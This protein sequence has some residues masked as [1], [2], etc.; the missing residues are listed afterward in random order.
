MPKALIIA[1]PNGAGKTSFASEF[2]A[3][4]EG[5]SM[6][7]LNADL[8]ADELDPEN[9][10]RVAFAAGK[11]MLQQLSAQIAGGKNF[12]LETTLA[13]RV[14]LRLIPQWQEAGYHVKLCFLKLPSPEL[15][16]ARVAH[17]VK[18]GGHHIPT[19]T[20]IRRYHRG[21]E[22]L[23]KHYLPLVDSWT[24]YDSSSKNYRILDSASTSEPDKL[25]EEPSTYP[26]PENIGEEERKWNITDPDF[27]KA[28]AA[29]QRAAEKAIARAHAAGLEPVLSNPDQGR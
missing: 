22:Y 6:T 17:R 8:I 3:N 23:H 4:E 24:I 20:I 18:L 1:G 15:A 13:T 28:G 10:E 19:D 16:I 5:D 29:L 2:L 7:F 26:A 27:I 14:Y 11:K 25:M 9:P 21:W 12:A